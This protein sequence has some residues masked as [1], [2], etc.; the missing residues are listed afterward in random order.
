MKEKDK[1]DDDKGHLSECESRDGK[2]RKTS[3]G[4]RFIWYGIGNLYRDVYV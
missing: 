2:W 1:A 4:I 3:N